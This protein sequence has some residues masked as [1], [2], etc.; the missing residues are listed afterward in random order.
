MCSAGTSYIQEIVYL[1]E[2]GADVR[3]ADALPSFMRVPY[4]ELIASPEEARTQSAN[5]LNALAAMPHGQCRLL[6]IGDSGLRSPLLCVPGPTRC[7][8]V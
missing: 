7:S 6:R 1:V 3:A 8:V 4:M 5:A 2:N